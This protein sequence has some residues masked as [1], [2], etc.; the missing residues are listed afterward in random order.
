MVISF[1]TKWGEFC[2]NT[3][4][5]KTQILAFQLSPKSQ[6][7]LQKGICAKVFPPYSTYFFT[8]PT[9]ICRAEIVWKGNGPNLS[10]LLLRDSEEGCIN[11]FDGYCVEYFDGCCVEYFDRYCVEYFDGYC[12]EYH[13]EDISIQG[14]QRTWVN[15]GE[16][17]LSKQ[18]MFHFEP[19]MRKLQKNSSFLAKKSSIQV[20]FFSVCI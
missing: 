6:S 5:W 12:V 3:I 4:D 16:I 10:H 17:F 13:I 2:L 15:G 19:N 9:Q 14:S 20:A 7:R 11:L 18:Q 1:L 8:F